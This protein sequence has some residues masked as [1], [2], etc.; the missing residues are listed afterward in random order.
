MKQRSDERNI[1]INN[2]LLKAN[3]NDNLKKIILDLNNNKLPKKQN[4]EFCDSEFRASLS[5]KNKFTISKSDAN[6][7]ENLNEMLNLEKIKSYNA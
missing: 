7:I 2:L 5:N 6:D 1:R 4:N 3:H